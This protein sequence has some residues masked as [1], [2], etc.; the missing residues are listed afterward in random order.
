MGEGRVQKASRGKGKVN[1]GRTLPAWSLVD[2]YTSP[3]DKR[4]SSDLRSA[5]KLAEAFRRKYVG[6]IAKTSQAATRFKKLLAEYEAIM[7]LAAKPYHYA[8][9]LFAESALESGRGSLLQMARTRYVE[10]TNLLAFFHPELLSLS[11]QRLQKLAKSKALGEY[12]N[13]LT[14]LIHYQKH[15][16]PEREK[17]IF[18]DMSL[19]GKDAVMRMF[20]EEFASR[21]YELPT[22]R[23]QQ[24]RRMGLEEILELLHSPDRNL[25]KRAQKGF[26]KGLEEDSRRL[27]LYFNTLLQEKSIRDRYHCFSKP[28]EARH[29]DNQITLPAA[30]SLVR[31][32]KRSFRDVKRFYE[33]KKELLGYKELYD[34]DRYAPLGNTKKIPWEKAREWVE[35][36]FEAF[37]P[38]FGSIAR[39]FFEKGW[40]DA[41]ARPGKRGGA[42]CSFVT[43]DLH[44]YVFLN[45][46][47]TERDVFTL[48]HELGH[49]IHAYLMREQSYLSFDSPLTIAETASVFAE[50]LLYDYLMKKTRSESVKLAMSIRHVE[51]IIATVHRQISMFQFERD[52]HAARKKG[53]LA[54]EDFN[55]LWRSR[56]EEMFQGAVTLTEGYDY[57]WSYIPHFV[58]SPFYVYAYAFGQ[59]LAL[60][61]FERYQSAPDTFPDKYRE[62]LRAGNSLSPQQLGRNMGIN[63]SK[64]D[65]WQQG[66]VAFRKRVKAAI[67][68]AGV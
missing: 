40:I 9:L 44:P 42:F 36:A 13:Y 47:G 34:Y 22:G 23:G 43:P 28:E 4:I 56:Q 57:W 67:K 61:L 48:A 8:S 19:V 39:E 51:N 14:Q 21:S 15:E 46:G 6:K 68:L 66:V 54:T 31:A 16:L 65:I 12:E 38:E 27:T 3:D 18:S 37:D 52:I 62:F 20:D 60:G 10:I 2:L 41:A 55:S 58:H 35:E 24:V 7:L 1:K 49:A 33:F 26:S 32:A 64:P 30:E 59:L 25:R 45:Y 53:E 63:L 5:G 50:L 17:Q 11:K 29:L